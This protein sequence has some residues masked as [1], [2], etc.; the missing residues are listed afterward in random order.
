MGNLSLGVSVRA[1]SL[2]DQVKTA[3]DVLTKRLDN[4]EAPPKA[5]PSIQPLEDVEANVDRFAVQL[6]LARISDRGVPCVYPA[7]DSIPVPIN[8]GITIP[9]G[10]SVEAFL[11][12]YEHQLLDW[13]MKLPET[14][15]VFGQQP[16]PLSPKDAQTSF[17]SRLSKFISARFSAT[18]LPP[19][20]AGLSFTVET[21]TRGGRV[22]VSEAYFHDPKRIFGAPTSPVRGRLQPGRY[23]FGV[24]SG[25]H[26]AQFD[27]EA[28]YDVPPQ[29][30]AR[31]D[32]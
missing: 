28:E 9:K 25:R 20:S 13:Y 22:H 2:A 23:I 7:G 30:S 27:L 14:K 24:S 17:V 16:E 21:R 32:L 12:D 8:L 18:T 26:P 10:V 29:G 1:A 4:P 15:S 11:I 3:V 6:H 31:V 5:R 19:S